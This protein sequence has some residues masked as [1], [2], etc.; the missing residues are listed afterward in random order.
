MADFKTT[1]WLKLKDSVV[2][3]LDK[4]I[5]KAGG[6]EKAIAKI[7]LR[8]QRLEEMSGKLQ[9]KLTKLTVGA[10][11]FA[12][13]SYGSLQFESGMARANTMA[14]LGVEQF[15]HLENQM[16]DTAGVIPV[17]RTQLTDGLYETI[18]NGVPENN[19]VQFLE[20]SSKAS[21]GSLAEMNEVVGVTATIIK[22]YADEWENAGAIQDK[23]QKTAVLGK[24]SFSE[25]GQ[26]LPRVTGS[27]A[28]LNVQ[29]DELLGAYAS[30]TGVTGNTS[31]V[32]T[33]LAAIFTAMVKPS[34][35]ATE[36]AKSMGIQFDSLSIKAA[37]GLMPFLDQL[38]ARTEAYAKSTGVNSTEIYA[39]LFGSAEA[40]RAFLPLTTSVSGDFR[41]KTAEIADSAGTIQ[42][43]F[44]QMAAT[45]T[46]RMQ[47]LRNRFENNMDGMVAAMMPVL[48]AGMTLFDGLMSGF[49]WLQTT[50]PTLTNWTVLIV[51]S[52]LAL[53]T[54]GLAI[55]VSA[56]KIYGWYGELKIAA[57]AIRAWTGWT[58]VATGA[59]TAW[60]TVTGFATS[61][62]GALNAVIAATP[63]GWLIAGLMLVV[64]VIAS[65]V[66]NWDMVTDAFGN[67][68]M[69]EGI[70]AI[71]KVLLDAVLWPIE[72]ILGAVASI[73]GADW[74]TKATES[75]A[76]FRKDML[77]IPDRPDQKSA[78]SKSKSTK[79]EK[80][81]AKGSKYADYGSEVTGPSTSPGSTE[82]GAAPALSGGSGGGNRVVHQ[83]N[84][85][86]I[87]FVLPQNWK[88]DLDN[89]RDSVME[90]FTNASGDAAI[91]ATK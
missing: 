31:E 86:Q 77:A 84:D 90:V 54:L 78:D 76:A 21:V 12:A 51:G 3:P 82:G 13:L 67:G 64:S 58:T 70:K 88:E 89:I 61:A 83:K 9:S 50:F 22:N 66:R 79:E 47:G 57:I 62:F 46:V 1:W 33:Q 32:S 35:E 11:A 4:I 75:L 68:G 27:A 91:A 69:L 56:L 43:A 15:H 7:Q 60:T 38:T 26:G 19:W 41:S 45:T 30:L 16:R 37:G 59:T 5:S 74:A 72:K 52:G 85:F 71:G 65:V 10:A 73:T 29:L 44:D 42:T 8:N 17:L 81:K 36:M 28:T 34:S 40:L 18:S 80:A 39:K 23:I 20:D 53:A 6:A 63:I 87:T 55:G 14:G 24:T 49:N 2:G 48:D 25:L